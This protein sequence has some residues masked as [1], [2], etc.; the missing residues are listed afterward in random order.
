MATKEKTTSRQ[1]SVSPAFANAIKSY[2][3]GRA[4]N[5]ELFAASYAK[6]GKNI[7]ECCNYILQEVR[8][9][10]R[11]GFADEEIYGMAVHYYDEDSIKDIKPLGAER[12]VVNH[13]IEL[14]ESEKEEMRQQALQDFKSEQLSA[15]RKQEKEREEKER[16]AREAR[17][18]KQKEKAEKMKGTQLSLFDM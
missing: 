17:I 15:L 9:S 12:V 18:K 3:D 11:A 16:L 13:T 1:G 2:L 10:G 5:D 7:D 4:K 14:S 6:P 8:A